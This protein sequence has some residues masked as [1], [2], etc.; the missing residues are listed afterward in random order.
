MSSFTRRDYARM[1]SEPMD[2]LSKQCVFEAFHGHGPGGQ[3]VNTADS[4]VRTTHVPTGIVVVSRESRSQYRNRQ[5]C[6]RKIQD[7]L[8]RRSVPPAV[9]HATK[10]THGSVLRRLEAKQARSRTKS[11]RGKIRDE[12]DL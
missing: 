8:R 4:A 12:R 11:L 6:L 3:G 5:L 7:E 1:A 9:R 10:P 2:E